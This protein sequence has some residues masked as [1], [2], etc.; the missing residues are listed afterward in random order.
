MNDAYTNNEWDIAK[1][2]PRSTIDTNL[3]M[4]DTCI[5]REWSIAKPGSCS[6]IKPFLPLYTYH[7]SITLIKTILYHP[8]IRAGYPIT[9]GVRVILVLFCYIEG[10]HYGPLVRVFRSLEGYTSVLLGASDCCYLLLSHPTITLAYHISII[11][12]STSKHRIIITSL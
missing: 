6:A 5:S 2:R 3:Y 4:I 1:N 11:L 8:N 7:T 12:I 10:F 9:A